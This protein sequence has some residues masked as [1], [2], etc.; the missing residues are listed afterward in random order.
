[1]KHTEKQVFHRISC[2]HAKAY[3]V[4]VVA[5]P[6]FVV[7]AKSLELRNFAGVTINT[8]MDRR[9]FLKSA[10]G[11]A[12]TAAVAMTGTSKVMAA[13]EVLAKDNKK[14]NGM[15]MEH[16]NLGGMNVS[17]IGLGCLPMVGYYGGHSRKRT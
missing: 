10:L 5:F 11:M 6:M 9:Y 3:S 13:T 2:F 7:I 8:I 12:L 17:A 14:R 4:I 16:R 1:M 15:K